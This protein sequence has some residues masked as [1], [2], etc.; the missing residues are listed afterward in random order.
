MLRGIYFRF[1]KADKSDHL[2][3]IVKLNITGDHFDMCGMKML[4]MASEPANWQRCISRS[5][6]IKAGMDVVIAIPAFTTIMVIPDE[7]SRSGVSLHICAICVAVYRVSSRCLSP[8]LEMV[9]GPNN[10]RPLENTCLQ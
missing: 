4:R 8:V 10:R 3:R 6:S 1:N 7:D 5:Q 9:N 2:A